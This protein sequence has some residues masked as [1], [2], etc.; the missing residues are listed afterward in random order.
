MRLGI[1]TARG[2]SKRI[3]RKNIRLFCGRPII[4]YSIQAALE[5]G[6]FDEVMVSTD[7]DD[8]ARVGC[9]YGAKVPFLRSTETSNDHATTAAALLEV[10]E[11]YRNLGREV[12]LACCIYPTA[13]FV[14][15]DRICCGLQMLESNADLISVIAVAQFAAPIQRALRLSDARVSLFQPEHL[16]SRSQDLEPAYHDAGQFY[17]LRVS[18]FMREPN[19]IGPRTGAQI[20]PAWEVQDIDNEEDWILA[21]A[22]YRIFQERRARETK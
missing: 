9:A 10:F 11:R 15:A 6:C 5:C 1:I 14:T 18:D 3:P 22:K 8:I 21:E 4:A 2:G 12:D 7:D 13:P 16:L 19:L 17:W 20:V